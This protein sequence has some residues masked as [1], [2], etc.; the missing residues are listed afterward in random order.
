[1]KAAARRG[2][3]LREALQA[4]GFVA[5]PEGPAVED[6]PVPEGDV[7][8]R[9]AQRLAKAL[10]GQT[11]VH[12][13]FRSPARHRRPSGGTVVETVSRATPADGDP[14]PT[15]SV[16]AAHPPEDG[17]L[18]AVYRG[19]EREPAAAWPGSSPTSGCAARSGS[20]LGIVEP[21]REREDDVV[22]HPAPTCSARTGT[23]EEA[24]R[25]LT[26]DP[27]RPLG[28]ALLDQRR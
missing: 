25:R 5:T 16:D 18:E 23:R 17:G 21:P 22:G 2:S 14:T 3:T 20:S 26:A 24:V 12:T 27:A 8:W 4:A 10:D 1:M 15:F 7:V 13:D 19:G 11:L 6:R 28:E 9:T